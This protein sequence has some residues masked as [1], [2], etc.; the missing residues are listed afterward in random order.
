MPGNDTY[1]PFD[2]SNFSSNIYFAWPAPVMIGPNP[3]WADKAMLRFLSGQAPIF[4][5]NPLPLLMRAV[6]A[7]RLR[8][9]IRQ[10]CWSAR[11]WR[12]VT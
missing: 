10:P 4:P 11:R 7:V 9:A 3:P 12:S 5:P 1:T 6:N 2:C 8:F